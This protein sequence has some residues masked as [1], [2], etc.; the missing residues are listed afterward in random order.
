MKTMF[1]GL[2]LI[3]SLAL[4]G[5][6]S[7]KDSLYGKWKQFGSKSHYDSIFQ[8]FND[9]YTHNF[10]YFFKNGNYEDVSY[11]HRTS[12]KGTWQF[13]SDSTRFEIRLTEL[14]D[15]EGQY[16]GPLPVSY[17]LIILKLTM[18]TL[19][20]GRETLYGPGKIKEYDYWYYCKSQ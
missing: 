10:I 13:N 19:V 5:Q 20:V 9:E 2:I 14:Q 17:N 6:H 18:D 8:T 16:Q 4:N 7:P 11:L 15:R 1:L 12:C 3:I